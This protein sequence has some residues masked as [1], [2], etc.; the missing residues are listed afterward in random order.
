MQID[1]T[2]KNNIFLPNNFIISFPNI[3]FKIFISDANNGNI[4]ENITCF[5]ILA[6]KL[7]KTSFTVT[8]KSLYDDEKTDDSDLTFVFAVGN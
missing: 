7:S 6:T 1:V 3:V 2:V 5:S 4:R 8:Y